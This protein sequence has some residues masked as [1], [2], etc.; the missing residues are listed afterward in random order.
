M[1]S[2]HAWSF[3]LV[4]ALAWVVYFAWIIRARR[5][6]RYV[7]WVDWEGVNAARKASGFPPHPCT[8]RRHRP[9]DGVW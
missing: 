7:D 8:P 9:R 2:F 3:A 1:S 6:R 5:R 4:Y